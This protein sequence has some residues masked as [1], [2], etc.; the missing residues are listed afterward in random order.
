MPKSRWRLFIYWPRTICALGLWLIRAWSANSKMVRYVLL[1][2]RRPELDGQDV[3]HGP[4]TPFSRKQCVPKLSR[5]PLSKNV[6]HDLVWP[7][8][9]E[10]EAEMWLV[11]CKKL[12]FKFT[13]VK[14]TR[15]K[16][17]PVLTREHYT[18]LLHGSNMGK[19]GLRGARWGYNRLAGARRG[20]NRLA[21]ARRGWA[22]LG[23]ARWG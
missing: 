18:S 15:L 4:S 14:K 13:G 22:E 10:L 8:R 7:W 2:P 3:V 11:C 1:R 21:G 16:I 9:P 19:E 5:R 20:Y 12:T 6:S 17:L 23:R